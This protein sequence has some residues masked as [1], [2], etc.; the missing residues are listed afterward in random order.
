MASTK[1]SPLI[2]VVVVAYDRHDFILAAVDSVVNQ[3]LEPNLFE[4][5]VIKNYND[6]KIDSHLQGLG[7]K[8]LIS[9]HLSLGSKV[10]EAVRAS[11]GRFVAILE[12]DDLF[13]KD[14]LE[15]IAP[16]LTDDVC[17]VH[18]STKDRAD[19][20][21]PRGQDENSQNRLDTVSCDVKNY[22]QIIKLSTAKPNFNC[23]SMTISRDLIIK[24]E[25]VISNLTYRLDVFLY[26]SAL[27]DPRKKIHVWNE[28]TGFRAHD[29]SIEDSDSFLTFR[30]E[31]LDKYR[32]FLGEKLLI[33]DTFEKRVHHYLLAGELAYLKSLIRLLEENR[34]SGTPEISELFVGLLPSFPIVSYIFKMEVILG[35]YLPGVFRNKLAMRMY[36]KARERY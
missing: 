1:R 33:K 4:I 15:K 3:T 27:S 16:L 32:K 28:L 6:P 31:R 23:S 13:N 26:L 29:Y 2:S 17:Y 9:S 30:N 22:G 8:N 19:M 35:S 24:N 20:A 34:K 18:N 10:A 21:G 36:V 14:K 7:V 25:E 12:D 5:V 11:S